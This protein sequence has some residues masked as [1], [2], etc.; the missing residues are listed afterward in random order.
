[1]TWN[2]AASDTAFFLGAS[3]YA[4]TVS[5]NKT[6]NKIRRGTGPS[7]NLTGLVTIAFAG[8]DSGVHSEASG[9]LTLSCNYSGTIT[10]TG[11]G[12]LEANNSNNTVKWRLNDGMLTV[13]A[14]NRFNLGGAGYKGSDFITFDGGGVGIGWASTF[15]SKTLPSDKGI[16]INAGGA[17]FGAASSANDFWI[18]SPI[19]DGTGGTGNGGLTVTTGSPMYSPYHAGGRLVLSNRTATVNSYRGPTRVFGSCTITLGS[20]NQIPDW[21]DVEVLGGTFANGGF[22]DTV[23][24]VLLD[25]GTISGAGVLTGTSYD[26][27]AGTCSSPLGGIG[28]VATKTTDGTLS[29]SGASTFTGG[30][31]HNEGTVRVNASAALGAANSPV[32]L[33]NGVTLSTTAGTAR[34][35]NYAYAVNGDIT[36]GQ[37]SGGV[38][39]LTLAGSMNLAGATRTI[40]VDNPTNTISAVITNGGFTKA[41]AGTLRLTGANTYAGPTTVN[42]GVLLTTTASTGGGSYTVADSAA[43]N[44]L[45]ASEDS[46]LRV[47]DLTMGYSTMEFDFARIG[48]T[49]SAVITNTGAVTVNGIIP[50]S[51]KGFDTVSGPV[52]L[53]QYAGSRGGWGNFT[54]GTFPPRVTATI[55][56]DIVNKKV[57]LTI[58]AADSLVWVGPGWWDVNNSGNYVWRL[59]SNSDATYYQEN[60]IQGDTVRFDDSAT[61]GGT[62]VDLLETLNPYRITVD[63][64]SKNYGFVTTGTGR[65]SGG[66]T[67]TKSGSGDLAIS[68]TNTYTG[69]TTLNA[70]SISLGF[71][72]PLGTGRLTINGGSL[73]SEDDTARTLSVPVTLN[74]NVTLGDAVKNGDLTLS[75]AWTISGGSRQITANTINATIS[76]AIGQ[77][78]AGRALTKAGNGTLSLTPAN[79]FSGG[80][81]HNAGTVRVNNNASL[82]AANSPVTLANGVTLS[83]T[84]T[85]GRTLTYDWTVNGNVTLG[86]ETGGT[87]AVTLAGSMNL[88]GVNR[89]FTTVTNATISAVVTN[90]GLTKMGFATLTLSGNNLYTGNTTN[91]QGAINPGTSAATPFGEG[92]TL[93]FEG[94]NI[95]T[96][97]GRANLPILNP[98]VMVTDTTF[99]GNTTGAGFRDFPISGPI[100]TSAGTLTLKNAGTTNG[101]WNTRLH[102]GGLNF[103][104]PIVVGVDGD[105]GMVQ[106]SSMNTGDTAA[107]TFSGVISGYGVF[108]RAASTNGTG[109]KAILTTANTYSGG[110]TVSDGT[111]LV[112]NTTGSG[113]GSGTVSLSSSGVLGGTGTIAGAVVAS[114]GGSINAGTSAGILTLQNGLDLSADGTNVWEL[115]ANTITGAGTSFDQISLTGGDLVLGGGSRI[116]VKFIGT[117]TFPDAGNAFWQSA[118]SWKIIAL[119]GAAANPGLTVF[120]GVDGAEGNTAGTFST[121]ADATGV[122]LNFTPGVTPPPP[123]IEPNIVGAGTANAALSWSSLSGVNY[124]VQYKNDLNDVNW[125][126]LTNITATGAKTT[127]VDSTTPVPAK[128][129]YRVLAP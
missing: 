30:F 93:R 22:A 117:A 114:N 105:T 119:S 7:A 19:I 107:Q 63:N 75:G 48:F 79:T 35:L 12:R 121:S 33:A 77:D 8:P 56:D 15:S 51:A 26:L 58:P 104:R 36:I 9:Y 6:V 29:I 20:T 89:T 55:T 28:V 40:R 31:H 45:L 111:L 2:N 23:G 53:L 3:A 60:A 16:T 27:R 46:S 83:T 44:I 112:N 68:T 17:F 109:G 66:A 72:T 90:G 52:T 21:S 71:S 18:E 38:G 125:S 10:K 50:V 103:T 82:G 59:A 123:V 80:F 25:T 92:G 96:S 113:T 49:G 47:S 70:G 99:E 76:G 32:I 73:R 84:T 67:L 57:I 42:E 14:A 127:I 122:Y 95:I 62:T 100:T 24:A 115:A 126:V 129:F 64:T 120:A 87:A 4:V 65:I 39:A 124:Q 118:R 13:A 110:T 43:L 97:G 54:E 41:G 102:A 94:G 98:I 34:T 106:L 69:G 81:N 11:P 1:V 101:I 108:N 86:Q 78:E 61:T 5:G 116:F 128:R 91:R 88:G 74:A 85:S 37:G